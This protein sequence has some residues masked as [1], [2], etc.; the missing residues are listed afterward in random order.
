[1][2]SLWW[3]PVAGRG[4]CIADVGSAGGVVRVGASTWPLWCNLRGV[5]ERKIA[6]RWYE[7][8]NL[9]SGDVIGMKGGGSG[10]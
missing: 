7:S 3:R 2:V 5:D 6:S 1:M 8:D 10:R 4:R 9:F